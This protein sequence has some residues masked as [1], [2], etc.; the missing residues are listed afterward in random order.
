MSGDPQGG[1]AASYKV[2]WDLHR[3]AEMVHQ[4]ADCVNRA[5][6][7]EGTIAYDIQDDPSLAP[8]HRSARETGLS[9]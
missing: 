1:R 2:S 9:L 3:A 6:E 8:S 7:V 5:H 4:V